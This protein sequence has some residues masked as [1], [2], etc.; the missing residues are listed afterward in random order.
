MSPHGRGATRAVRTF[1]AAGVAIATGL[2]FAGPA[3]AQTTPRATANVKAAIV[4]GVLEVTGTTGPDNIVLLVSPVDAST[5]DVIDAATGTVLFAFAGSGFGSVHLSMLAGND[6]VMGTNGIARFGP[7]TID[8]GAGNDVLLGGDGADTIIGGTGNDMIDGNLGNDLVL[9]GA[10]NDTFNWDPG[11]GSDVVEGDAGTDTM[12]FNGSNAAEKIDLSANGSRLRFTRDVAAITMDVNAVE[13]VTVNAQ[14]GADNV[15]VDDLTGTGVTNATIEPGIDGAADHVTVNGTTANDSIAVGADASGVD[16]TGLATTVRVTGAEP[17]LDALTVDGVNG[18]DTITADP[19][20]GQFVGV[21]ADG[22]NDLDTVVVNGTNA[23]DTFGF[24]EN[25]AGV[26]V[27][28]GAGQ[29]FTSVAE[30]LNLNTRGGDDT[31]VGQN[32]VAA[33][34]NVTIDGGP[35]NDDLEGGDGTDTII[36]GTGSDVID[37]NRGN[38][39]ELGGGGNDTFRWDPGDGNDVLEGQAGNDTLQFDGSNAAEKI[40][41]SPNG[42][43]LRLSR[44]VAAVVQ[45]A[46]GVENVVVN[47]LAA[48]DT[49]TVND[50]TGTGVHNAT[51]DLAGLDGNGDLT[52]DDVIV[53]GTNGNDNV[54]V[55]GV[56]GSGS[57]Q[58]TGLDPAVV[59][60]GAEFGF[61]RLDVNTLAGTDHVRSHLAPAVISLFVNGAPA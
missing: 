32:G 34:T 23:A 57:A 20:V 41:L 54:T 42:T 15:T 58:V 5:L 25:G 60:N 26:F 27:V 36:G 53:N 31:V 45:D 40:D 18:N 16:V 33:L 28:N 17:A 1:A 7:L 38:D 29:A 10:G 14:G 6:T 21:V 46:A 37:G 22:G 49:V 3:A 52:A 44:D 50:L 13:H 59:V 43:R 4:D 47:T 39:V 24:G 30:L 9:M 19:A 8:G 12:V 35:G 48:A 56:A 61:D 2:S 55:N 51:I 11:D